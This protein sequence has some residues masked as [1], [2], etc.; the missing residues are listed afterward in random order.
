MARGVPA[1]AK[2]D[3]IAADKS[4]L[5]SVILHGL[6]GPVTVNGK[7]Y[8]SVMPPMNQLTDDEVANIR[9]LCA[10]QLGQP[11]RQDHQGRGRR[12]PRRQASERIGRSL[13]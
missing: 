1:A 9:H 3:Y 8:N 10:Q 11:G 13:R 6:Q 4:R 7:D 12:R 5:A 2:S